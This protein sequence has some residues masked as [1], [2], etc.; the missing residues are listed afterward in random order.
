VWPN[1][2]IYWRVH[3]LDGSGAILTTSATRSF[4]RDASTAGEFTAVAPYRVLDTR[5]SG[6]PLRQGTTRTVKVVGGL[7]GIPS[8]GVSAVVLNAT[9]TGPT[10]ASY[11]TLWPAGITRPT[12]STLNFVAGQTVANHATIP[13]DSMGRLSMFV[14]RGDTHVILDVVGYYSNG[15]L[16]R[17]NRYTPTASPTRIVDTRTAKRPLREREARLVEVAGRAGVPANASAVV[18][19]VTAV[20][21]TRGGFFTVYPAGHARPTASSLNF[22][23]GDDVPNLVTMPLGTG[24]DVI[25]YNSAG[26][27]QLVVDVV[28]W[29]QSGDPAPGARMNAMTPTRIADTRGA[30]RPKL[31]Q[32][33][34]RSF[35]VRGV[36]GVPNDPKVTGVVIN[37][38]VTD[39]VGY[40]YATVYPSRTAVPTASNLNYTSGQTVANQVLAKVGSDGKV[41]VYTSRSANVVIDVVGWL[42]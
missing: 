31:G 13:V 15:K 24:G 20:D 42:R 8:S 25:V 22:M 29:Y 37:V 35:P 40:G 4:T 28:G 6:G 16:Q 12:V 18:M 38:T 34:S 2:T 19:N 23:P 27:T 39:P 33:T 36:G 7:T 30:Q 9:V 1:G 14:F 41:A 26:S 32:R 10:K 17:A 3:A 5:S 21:P 11:L